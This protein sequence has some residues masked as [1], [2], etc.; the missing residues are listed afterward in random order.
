[1]LDGMRF[2]ELESELGRPVQALDFD[3]F[4]GMF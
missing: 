2:E 4:A 3:S 1:M